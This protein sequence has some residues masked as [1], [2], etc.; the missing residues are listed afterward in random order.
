MKCTYCGTGLGS[1]DEHTAGDEVDCPECPAV[2][3]I[4]REDYENELAMYECPYCGHDNKRTRDVSQIRCENK[5]CDLV[6]DP[7]GANIRSVETD[8]MDLKMIPTG[9]S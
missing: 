9:D 8:E 4:R 5:D 2:Y 6:F 3:D 7:I 1:I